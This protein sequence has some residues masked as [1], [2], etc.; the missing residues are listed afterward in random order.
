M[1][2]VTKLEKAIHSVFSVHH[3]EVLDVSDGCGESYSILLVSDVSNLAILIVIIVI[4]LTSCRT[5]RA[6]PPCRN[7]EKVRS[8]M[9]QPL[10]V[11]HTLLLQ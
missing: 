5:L 6:K 2:S 9:M 11:V 8:C 3:L 1:I 10:P 4:L 7:I